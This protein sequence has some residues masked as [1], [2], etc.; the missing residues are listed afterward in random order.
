MKRQISLI[1]CFVVSAFI[2]YAVF[3]VPV[4]AQTLPTKPLTIESIYQP[5][6][7]GGRGL[8]NAEWS[9]NGTKLTYVQR[10]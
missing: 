7:L 5:G 8:E 4:G 3:A 9:P 10:D 1:A 2:F 6:G